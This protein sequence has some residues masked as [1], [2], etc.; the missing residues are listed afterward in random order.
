MKKISILI[1]VF[2]LF[3]FFTIDRVEAISKKIAFLSNR[4]LDGSDNL[5]SNSTTNIW[6]MNPDGS[7]LQVLAPITAPWVSTSTHSWSPDGTKILFVSDRALDGS[8]AQNPNGVSNIW[9]MNEDG[10][11]LRPLAPTTVA[12]TY[13]INPAWSPDGTKIAFASDRA[14]DGSDAPNLNNSNNIWVMNADG[15]NLQVLSPITA[16]AHSYEPA[17]SPD[18]SQIAFVSDR[19][20]N[21]SDAS[22]STT[23]LW[24]V[25][26]DGTNARPLA[27]LPGMN[28]FVEN[29]HP[30]WSPIGNQIAFSS[31][32]SFYGFDEPNSSATPNIWVIDSNG[33]NLRV[34]APV[35]LSP[36]LFEVPQHKPAWSPDGTRIAFNSWRLGRAG[37]VWV[38]NEDGSNAHMLSPK[39][40]PQEGVDRPSWSFDG[41]QITFASSRDLTGLDELSVNRVYN[42]WRIN[43]DGTN[44][45]PL[46]PMMVMSGDNGS[47]VF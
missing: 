12:W 38:V 30:T 46:V 17:W 16:R 44:P 40:K 18:G 3:H 34:L 31:N 24:V 42:I 21:G 35:L 45:L 29:N 25:N 2:I 8:D 14:F 9:V 7:N 32:R 22:I 43:S 41:K 23:N 20:I 13:N 15:S 33:L 1:L 39:T 10:S 28:G 6:V 36:F 4:A 19:A 27:P 37:N 5:N 11:N 47:P 26:S